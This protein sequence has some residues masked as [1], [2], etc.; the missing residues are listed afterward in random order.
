[1]AVPSFNRLLKQAETIFSNSH[2]LGST[3]QGH[4]FMW[5]TF[6]EH[7]GVQPF[8]LIQKSSPPSQWRNQRVLQSRK[9]PDRLW[10]SGD[11]PWYIW[12][13]TVTDGLKM[14]LGFDEINMLSRFICCIHPQ[15]HSQ[16]M[17][18]WQAIN[19]AQFALQTL[20]FLDYPLCSLLYLI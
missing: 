2:L 11:R 6:A 14:G 10:H 19:L 7:H 17:S 16:I 3:I 9:W 4:L 15:S 20:A 5:T 12:F 8:P 1:M 13:I 18:S